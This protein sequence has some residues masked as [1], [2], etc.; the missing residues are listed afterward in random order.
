MVRETLERTLESGD[1]RA[2]I[3]S[4]AH[5]DLYVQWV[6]W[7]PSGAL[8]LEVSNPANRRRSLWQRLRRGGDKPDPAATLG[9]A[10][11][12]ALARLGFRDG[13][14]NYEREIVAGELDRDQV[15]DLLATTVREALGAGDPSSVTVDVL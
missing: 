7:G 8:H 10:Q 2:V 12:T 6:A 1:G 13:S 5:P 15:A 14:P 3:A 9:E 4:A 11:V